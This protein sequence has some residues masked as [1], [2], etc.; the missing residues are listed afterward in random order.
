M[1]GCDKRKGRA[2]REVEQCCHAQK[3]ARKSYVVICRYLSFLLST[4]LVC[5]LKGT[6]KRKIFCAAELPFRNSTKA[7]L[8]PRGGPVSQKRRKNEI[9]VATLLSSSRTNLPRQRILTLS[10]RAQ[11]VFLSVQIG[12]IVS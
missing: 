4:R 6:L 5:R 3:R 2:V 7:T 8:T 1:K 11:L 12:Y 10:A 9:W